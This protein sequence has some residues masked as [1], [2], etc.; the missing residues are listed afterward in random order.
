[1][2]VVGAAL[3]MGLTPYVNPYSDDDVT[4]L[5]FIVWANATF[6]TPIVA[7]GSC[8]ACGFWMSRLRDKR[9]GIPIGVMLVCVVAALATIP[10]WLEWSR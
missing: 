7:I 1:M 6:L 10:Q 5:L 8:V 2:C 4:V 9:V 3:S